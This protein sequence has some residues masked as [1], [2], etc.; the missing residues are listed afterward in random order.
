MGSPFSS[1]CSMLLPLTVKVAG[2]P[3]RGISRTFLLSYSTTTISPSYWLG[4]NSSPPAEAMRMAP[5]RA[6]DMINCLDFKRYTSLFQ[7]AGQKPAL[8]L[9]AVSYTHLDGV[10]LPQKAPH[11]VGDDRRPGDGLPLIHI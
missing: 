8:S 9:R 2:S 7:P 10:R 1:S 4:L 3:L 6:M 11:G 5:S